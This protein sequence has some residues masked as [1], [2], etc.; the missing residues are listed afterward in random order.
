ML[1]RRERGSR[2]LVGVAHFTALVPLF[3]LAAFATNQLNLI[4]SDKIVQRY[5]Y[6][7]VY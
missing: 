5:Y 7:T 4:F 6:F 3:G 1:E 2:A